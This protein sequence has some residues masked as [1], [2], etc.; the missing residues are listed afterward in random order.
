MEVMRVVTLAGDPER[1]ADLAPRLATEPALEL[2]MRC[3]DRVELLATMR[4]GSIDAIIAVGSP[5]WFDAQAAR[6]AARARIRVVGVAD[7]ALESEVLEQRG[8]SVLDAN[9][10]VG[11][12]VD[13]CRSAKPSAPPVPLDAPRTS[14]GRVLAI[15]GPKGAPGRT[16]IAIELAYALSGTGEST[17][18]VD[19]DPYG[20][21]ALQMLGVVE[22]L[23]TIL[24]AAAAAAS[25]EGRR[26]LVSHL[27]KVGTNGPLLVPG[28]PRAELW[29]EVDD[30][31][32]GELIKL[33]AAETRFVVVD[34]GFGLEDST[35]L[36]ARTGRNA[37]ARATLER[38]DRVIAVCRADPVGVKNFIWSFESL[39][40]LIEDDRIS[41]V[42]N[43]LCGGEGREIDELLTR[44]TGRRSTVSFPERADDCRKSLNRGGALHE[45]HPSS[46]ICSHARRL[47]EQVGG[48]VQA[49]GLL[50]R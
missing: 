35:F 6:E 26:D 8:V 13:A 30:F 31:G 14:S 37:M 20:G 50:A 48:K 34:V 21:D 2:Y 16:T 38:A 47:A 42:L 29:A 23:P 18:L 39:R 3:V 27:R 22:E 49:Q 5:G 24:W 44:N 25:E 43:R 4:S 19:A 33:L 32:Y 11:E 46:E 10:S 17:V 1:E 15:W 28:L 45:V 9:A 12:I 36:G 41:V 40:E 7:N